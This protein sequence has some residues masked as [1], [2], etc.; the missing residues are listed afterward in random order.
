MMRVLLVQTGHLGDLVLTTPLVRTLVRH[1]SD[2]RVTVLTTPLG[3][4]LL[5]GF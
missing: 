5:G 1:D 4:E 2:S 3:E